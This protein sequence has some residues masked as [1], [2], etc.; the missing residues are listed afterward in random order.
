MN[1]FL[2]LLALFLSPFAQAARPGNTIV[3]GGLF[4]LTGD[5][6]TLGKASEAALALAE[7]DINAELTELRIPYRVPR[8]MQT[9]RRGSA[10]SSPRS[11]KGRRI[12]L[13][14]L[15]FCAI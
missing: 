12:C 11:R 4:S 10:S 7:R 14:D 3:V 5:G 8:R 1:R 9:R 15:R 2:C 6:A 13:P